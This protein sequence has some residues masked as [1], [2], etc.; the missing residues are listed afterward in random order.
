MWLM[1]HFSRHSSLR[2]VPAKPPVKVQLEPLSGP[3]TPQHSLSIHDSFQMSDFDEM[4]LSKELQE[5]APVPEA[6]PVEE[7]GRETLRQDVGWWEDVEEREEERRHSEVNPEQRAFPISAIPQR[8][9]P[10]TGSP[11]HRQRPVERGDE[12]FEAVRLQLENTRAMT[13]SRGAHVNRAMLYTPTYFSSSA[14][15]TPTQQQRKRRA[16]LVA[17]GFSHKPRGQFARTT[18]RSKSTSPWVGSRK[19][20]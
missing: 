8:R 7:Q 3:C 1:A 6:G 20:R 13:P 16:P 19:H 18:P 17:E 9:S 10:R 4:E 11:P 15:S 5:L 2:L 14:R 12:L